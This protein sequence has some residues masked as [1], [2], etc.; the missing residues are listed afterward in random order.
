M[1][2]QSK[3]RS[4]RKIIIV[5][6]V[7]LIVILAFAYYFFNVFNN[8]R[9]FKS[10]SSKKLVNPVSGLSL[11][12][13]IE[14][15][16]DSYIRYLLISIGGSRLHP[17]P[18]SSDTPKIELN[19]GN[20]IYY[21]VVVDGNVIVGEGGIEN[22][23]AVI[24]TDVEEIVKMLTDRNYILESYRNGLTRAEAKVSNLELIS[25]GYLQLYEEFS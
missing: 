10:G 6:L 12:E 7:L 4:L 9:F 13:G 14:N 20:R 15:F 1:K 2:V 18:F 22:E 8:E 17:P 11:E 3:Q 21:S 23:D 5:S 19:V 16:D 24:T 25:K